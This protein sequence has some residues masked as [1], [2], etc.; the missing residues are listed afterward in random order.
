V[1][2]FNFKNDWQILIKFVDFRIDDPLKKN[3][4]IGFINNFGQ[5]PKQLF[6]KPH[7]SKR[8][9]SSGGSLSSGLGIIKQYNILEAQNPLMALA[10]TAGSA[11]S[12]QSSSSS[13]EKLFYH[14]VDHLRPTLAPIKELKGPVGKWSYF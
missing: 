1:R 14:H 11:V 13:G 4:T 10:A 3:A 2:N 5:I 9:N 12:S 8:V 6:K 7:P